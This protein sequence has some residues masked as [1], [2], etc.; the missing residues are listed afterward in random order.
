MTTNQPPAPYSAISSPKFKPLLIASGIVIVAMFALSWWAW[1]QVPAGSEI[2]V[3]W[4]VDGQ[5][6]RYGGKFEGLMLMPLIFLG[7]T[8]LFAVIPRIDPR[9]GNILRS[10]GAYQALWWVML[11]FF[12]VLHGVLILNVLGYN[13]SVGLFVPAG[14]GVMFLV[15]G[16]YMGR[17][18]S[19]YMM[20]IRTPWTLTSE[21]SWQK[22]HLWGGR[23]FML[24]GVLLALTG[25]LP[26]SGWWIGVLMGGM[27]AMI[28][29]LFVYSYLV[30]KGDPNAERRA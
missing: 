20:G 3:H 5:P 9:G 15:I 25:F 6:D 18:R 23:A 8:A 24:L 22:T 12:G 28:I 19:N 14:V 30:W 29:G 11:A 7:I 10:E 26:I 2:P 27:L 21:L 4:G 17:M 13:V 16:Y 1:G